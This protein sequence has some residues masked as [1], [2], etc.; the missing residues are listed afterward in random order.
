VDK[1]VWEV[2]MKA[3]ELRIES[4]FDG[5]GIVKVWVD[6]HSPEEIEDIVVWLELARTLLVKWRARRRPG[7][8]VTKL[9]K[10]DGLG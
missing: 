8:T 10:R 3:T 5:S 1:L 7:A 9:E 2:L 6:C 4:E